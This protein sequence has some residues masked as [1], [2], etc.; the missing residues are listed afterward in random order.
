MTLPSPVPRRIACFLFPQVMMLDVTGPMQVFASANEVLARQGMPP[1]YRLETVGPQAGV[2]ETS[3][4]LRMVADH[5]MADWDATGVDTLL[6]AGGNGVDALRRDPACLDWLRRVEPQVRRLGSVC[7]GALLLAEA[8]LLTGRAVTT[9]WCRGDDI[10][11]Y[12]GLALDICRLHTYAPDGRDGDP[13]V[14]TSAG[15]TAG[16]DLAMA[17]V[18]ADA[19]PVVALAVARYLVLFLRRPGD[20]AQF[21]AHLGPSARPADADAR[22][23]ALLDWLPAN[24]SSD[25][26]VE[27]LAGRCGLAPR[28]FIRRFVQATGQPPGRYVESLRLEAARGLLHTGS[29]PVAEVAR[30]CGYDHPEALR[31]AFQKTLRLSPADYARR[32]GGG[33]VTAGTGAP[34]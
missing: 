6:I 21:S 32:F 28:T 2:V 9:H 11:A 25:L 29:I 7:S 26:T 13:H 34:S 31:R 33:T 4:G 1:L 8:G 30:R 12:P 19:G 23:L 17:L 20:Q 3:S 15:V 22:L 24:L 14:F 18:E 5:A 16:I 27:A 10:A